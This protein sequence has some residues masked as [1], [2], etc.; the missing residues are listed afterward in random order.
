MKRK[1]EW[2]QR[3]CSSLHVLPSAVLW[4]SKSPHQK[5]G[6]RSQ[7]SQPPEPGASSTSI[8]YPLPD[9]KYFVTATEN[10]WRQTYT[11]IDSH[12]PLK[13]NINTHRHIISIRY[14]HT[15]Y[16]S[17]TQCTHSHILPCASRDETDLGHK[18][19]EK[20]KQFISHSPKASSGIG[21]PAFALA[22]VQEEL[23]PKAWR[24]RP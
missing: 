19:Q 9:L 3:A 2:S 20:A 12:T 22:K 4:C 1:N 6:R 11:N 23:V 5:L 10:R 13:H 8:P 18:P 17:H 21:D 16:H 14:I 24:S 7:S 15:H